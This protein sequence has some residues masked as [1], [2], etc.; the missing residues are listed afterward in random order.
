MA[1]VISIIR[2][3]SPQADGRRRITEAHTDSLGEVYTRTYLAPQ[4]FDA[5]GQLASR[6][7]DL[8]ERL[9]DREYARNVQA[10]L[11]GGTMGFTLNHLTLAQLQARLRET[12]AESS[13]LDSCRLAAYFVTLS[14]AAL[15]ALFRVPAGQVST[16]RARLQERADRATAVTGTR[17]E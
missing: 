16:L 14:N 8:E 3:D 17:G 13:M 6:A 7:V 15:Q 1:I 5:V 12:F 2:E 4:D 10:I 11:D 9:A